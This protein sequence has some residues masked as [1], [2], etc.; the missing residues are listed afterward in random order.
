MADIFGNLDSFLDNYD[1]NNI[2]S[3]SIL[4]DTGR[5][6]NANDSLSNDD[7]RR[8][9]P[10]TA[11]KNKTVKKKSGSITAQTNNNKRTQASTVTSPMSSSVPVSSTPAP[12]PSVVDLTAM[13]LLSAAEEMQLL[14][15][16]FDSIFNSR[17]P[18]VKELLKDRESMLIKRSFSTL[19]NSYNRKPPVTAKALIQLK[20][21]IDAVRIKLTQLDQR[22]K[23]VLQPE[24][25]DQPAPGSSRTRTSIRRN[26]VRGPVIISLDCDD[27]PVPMQTT[28]L[29]SSGRV[30][31]RS[32]TNASN[33]AESQSNVITLDS[34]DDSMPEFVGQVNNPSKANNSFETENYVMRIKVKWTLGIEMF[35]YRRF[36]K[37]ADMFA[38]LA[39]K[40][41]A[42][43]SCIFLNLDDRIVY[44]HDTPDSINYKPNQFISGRIFRSKAPGLPTAMAPS[45]SNNN[46]ISLKIQMET[47]KQPLRL[48]I[49][50]QQTMSVLVIK[51][52]EELKCAPKDIKLYFDGELIDNSS[53]PEDLDLEGD[54]IL[55]IRFAK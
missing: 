8:Q 37:F 54:E 25:L 44:P 7:S 49:D 32:R 30:T 46:T 29:F 13:T 41:S 31:R 15:R 47:R 33:A 36:Q 52:A 6:S 10:R 24:S 14:L 18:I 11:G 28:N 35:E 3:N 19:N 34:D 42:D 55:D 9:S 12:A 22:I 2:S 17:N 27:D 21:K 4:F 43:S 48:Q 16:L 23:S 39:A 38:Q 53:K 45:A 5:G 26:Q 51:C 40:E 20:K 50:K 1:E